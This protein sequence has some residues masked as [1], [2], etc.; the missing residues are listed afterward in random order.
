M[1]LQK[2][3]IFF[4]FLSFHFFAA[5]NRIVPKN[6]VVMI[7]INRICRNPDVFED[8]DTF[9]PERFQIE[10]QS[11]EKFNPFAFIPFSAGPRNCVGQKFAMHE[12]KCIVSK[13]LRN[14]EISLTKECKDCDLVL[15]NE[16]IL[17]TENPIKFQF[18]KRN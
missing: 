12:I 5:K 1:Y 4:L 7:P 16:I 9:K 14:F 8:P 17:R 3:Y 2:I 15:C 10:N 11:T 6:S 18:K 13:I